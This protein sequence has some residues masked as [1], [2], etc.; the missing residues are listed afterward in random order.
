MM[1]QRRVAF[2]HSKY[3]LYP[4]GS[5]VFSVGL[6]HLPLA[7]LETLIFAPFLYFMGGFTLDAG[8]FFIFFAILCCHNLAVSGW[9]RSLA[10]FAPNAEVA[11]ILAVQSTSL[12][13]LF[14][15][16]LLTQP[17]IPGWFIWLFWISPF[18]WTIRA[19]ALNEFHAPRYAHPLTM[20]DSF[21]NTTLT[22]LSAGDTY[23]AAWDIE[24]SDNF[25]WSAGLYLIIF[26]LIFTAASGLVLRYKVF[27][28]SIGTRR[29]EEK[30]EDSTCTSH[31]INA[32]N[33]DA[34][35]QV[36]GNDK[37]K[38]KEFGQGLIVA[39]TTLSF[40]NIKFAVQVDDKSDPKKKQPKIWRTLLRNVTGYARPVSPQLN[41]FRSFMIVDL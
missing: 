24:R 35:L 28:L 14:G 33:R 4:G 20:T 31:D 36:D 10:W 22:T 11:Q 40:N 15:G 17:Q 7:A 13:Y 1:E 18:A 8:R 25:I 2:K 19:C 38:V 21:G 30:D 32:I 5:Y 12:F 23:L 6:M 39:P 26:W 29:S 16:F 37:G 3:R 34:A 41:L 9:F 27:P